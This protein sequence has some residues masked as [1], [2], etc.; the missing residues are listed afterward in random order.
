MGV[1]SVIKTF[2]PQIIHV[3]I[4]EA[5][6]RVPHGISIPRIHIHVD[7]FNRVSRRH[8][9][10]RIVLTLPLYDSI[11]SPL[12]VRDL[13]ITSALPNAKRS[14]ELPFLLLLLLRLFRLR[15]TNTRVDGTVITTRHILCDKT[16]KRRRFIVFSALYHR[17][18][19]DLQTHVG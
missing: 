19:N 9:K 17:P 15:T 2:Q 10:T 13:D 1:G 16:V 12:C 4:S 3:R 14:Q 6:S 18:L 8:Y 11:R 5:I 7:A